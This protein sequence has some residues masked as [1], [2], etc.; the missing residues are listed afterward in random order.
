V[1]GSTRENFT[2]G[3]DGW[4]AEQSARAFNLW[5]TGVHILDND[6]SRYPV[7]TAHV[8]LGGLS[9]DNTVE[10]PPGTIVLDQGSNNTVHIR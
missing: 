2:D 6:F 4:V 5:E 1:S 7:S 8:W 3:T 10:G 9:R